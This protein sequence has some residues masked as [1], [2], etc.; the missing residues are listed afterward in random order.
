ME[1][2]ETITK[3]KVEAAAANGADFKAKQDAM[4]AIGGNLSK[5]R[6]AMAR[7]REYDVATAKSIKD[8]ARVLMEGTSQEMKRLELISCSDIILR[9]QSAKLQLLFNIL[10]CNMFIT[11]PYFI[12]V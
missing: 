1:L 10:G 3:M 2:E 8:L 12:T 6:Q 7:Q 11:K 5:L 9:C 4:R